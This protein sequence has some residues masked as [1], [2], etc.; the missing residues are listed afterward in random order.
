MTVKLDSVSFGTGTG[1]SPVAGIIAIPQSGI[2][3]DTVTPGKFSVYP[4][5]QN[6][7]YASASL[8]MSLGSSTRRWWRRVRSS[9]GV[10]YTQVQI[11]PGTAPDSALNSG[12]WIK[13]SRT[14]NLFTAAYSEDGG[15]IWI[16]MPYQANHP[17]ADKDIAINLGAVYVGLWVAA[18]SGAANNGGYTIAGFSEWSFVNGDGNATQAELNATSARINLANF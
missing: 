4:T 2:T 6:L 8:S 1:T 7:R 18:G 13:L 10:D 12:R 5:S 3:R 14:G 9:T 11:G 15:A 17:G 16:D